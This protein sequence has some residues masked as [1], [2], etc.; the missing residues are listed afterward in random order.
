MRTGARHA[1]AAPE[2]L[3]P[4]RTTTAL[5]RQPAAPATAAAASVRRHD[6]SCRTARRRTA[7][8]FL[9]WLPSPQPRPLPRHATFS[10]CVLAAPC[11][12]WLALWLCLWRPPCT[13]CKRL[14]LR[15]PTRH[16]H[17][18]AALP[19]AAAAASRCAC[20]R[21]QSGRHGR[22]RA[23]QYF[24]AVSTERGAEAEWA[25]CGSCGWCWTFY[26]ATPL[27]VSA[28]CKWCRDGG[29]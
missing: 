28:G 8:P 1:H 16:A 12:P 2:P 22:R 20:K 18:R 27:R 10:N 17:K 7:L 3:L 4:G 5:H 26:G 25:W 15:E 9:L 14:R 23:L 21:V 29:A 19:T 13:L 24:G 11:C 6:S